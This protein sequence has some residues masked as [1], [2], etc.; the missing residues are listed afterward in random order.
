MTDADVY[1]AIAAAEARCDQ[2]MA[3]LLATMRSVL[4]RHGLPE[5]ADEP[6]PEHCGELIAFPGPRPARSRRCE[7]S[8]AITATTRTR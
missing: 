3:T 7:P 1:D 8:A 4:A 2:K 5:F 6:G